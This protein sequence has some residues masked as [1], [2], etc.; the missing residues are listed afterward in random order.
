MKWA[1]G[2]FD[3]IGEIVSALPQGTTLLEPFV[4]SGAVFLNTNY[5]KYILCDI[6]KDLINL[7]K[8]VQDHGARFI[9]DAQEYFSQKN[10]NESAFYK[11]RKRFNLCDDKYEKSLLF[12]YLN[13]HC[14]NGLCRYNQSGEFN[15][16]FGRY[17]RPHFPELQLHEFFV[18]SKKA[19]F[20]CEPFRKAFLRAKRGTVIYCDPP[21]FPLSRTAN[22]TTFSSDGFST[23]AQQELAI[24]AK[25]SAAKGMPTL[26]SNHDVPSA[27]EIYSG[28]EIRTLKVRRRISSKSLKRDSVDEVL[29]LYSN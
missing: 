28:A 10:N 13:R 9:V 26:I 21:Y 19:S 1:G 29:A 14:Y 18:R 11:F 12:L 15:V 27:R 2:K 4:G 3:L 6:N 24:L 5:E 17:R 20:Y 22:F 23:S 7:Y 25:E 16:P 8:A